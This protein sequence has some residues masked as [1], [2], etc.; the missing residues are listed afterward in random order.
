MGT[1]TAVGANRGRSAAYAAF[2]TALALALG[3]ALVPQTALASTVNITGGGLDAGGLCA[4]GAICPAT[5]IDGYTYSS[6]GAVSGSL[7]YNSGTDKAD[8]TFTLTANTYFGGEELQSGAI[9]SASGINVTVTPG[10]H[11]TESISLNTPSVDG[12]TTNVNFISPTLG[13]TENNPLLSALTCSLTA[14]GGTC[15]VSLG[16]VNGSSNSLLLVD[17]SNNAYNAYLTFNV[18]VAPAAVPLPPALPLLLSGIAGLG[19]MTR[20]RRASLG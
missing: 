6:G 20:C 10:T 8:F 17:G 9:F 12:S 13:V 14:T 11:G 7:D 3:F 2:G 4:I 1:S 16:S 15:G 5:P 19:V 18:D